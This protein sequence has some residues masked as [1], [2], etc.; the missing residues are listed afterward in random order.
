MG[1]LISSTGLNRTDD[2]LSA[3]FDLD[4]PDADIRWMIAAKALERID[5]LGYD[6][7]ALQSMTEIYIPVLYLCR[8]NSCRLRKT[9]VSCVGYINDEAPEDGFESILRLQ[10]H[11][12]FNR[13]IHAWAAHLIVLNVLIW[14]C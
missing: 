1:L 4:V 7:C 13:T 14:C 12:K 3:R 11:V 10:A 8:R 2:R 9:V 6:R 5:E